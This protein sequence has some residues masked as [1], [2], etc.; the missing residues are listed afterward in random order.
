MA[1][2]GAAMASAT[3]DLNNSGQWEVRPVFK[4]GAAG[5]D[6]FNR[7][8]AE[9][10]AGDSTCPGQSGPQG[11][12]AI[13][14]DGKVITAPTIDNPSFERDQITISGSFTQA[15]ARALTIDLAYGALPLPVTVQTGG[16]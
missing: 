3:S 2:T 6:R 15:Q 11:Q 13:V 1:L 7:L 8:A 4:A 16:H 9:C 10:Y 12:A 5:I 14:L